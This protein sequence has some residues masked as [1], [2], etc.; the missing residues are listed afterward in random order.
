MRLDF[1][2]QDHKI[3]YISKEK[4][5]A[6]MNKFQWI[7]NK[8]KINIKNFVLILIDLKILKL[9]KRQSVQKKI[10]IHL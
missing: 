4:Q 5:Y 2:E 8:L 6:I 9:M 7:E 3:K 10:L 1:V